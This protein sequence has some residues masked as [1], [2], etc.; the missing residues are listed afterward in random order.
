MG[1]RTDP[2]PLKVKNSGSG[3]H[4]GF[5]QSKKANDLGA[6]KIER[7]TVEHLP[8]ITAELAGGWRT[9]KE[10]SKERGEGKSRGINR[11]QREKSP[12]LLGES[13]PRVKQGDVRKRSEVLRTSCD[14]L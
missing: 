13:I 7:R 3:G 11:H 6:N 1:S 9:L 12:Q 14:T 4:E 8:E 5:S 2:H 10:S